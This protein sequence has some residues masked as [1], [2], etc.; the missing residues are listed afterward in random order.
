MMKFNNGTLILMVAV[1]FA[2]AALSL[3]I[4]VSL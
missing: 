3:A 4:A 1:L 2:I